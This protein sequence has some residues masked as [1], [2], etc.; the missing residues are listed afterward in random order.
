[1]ATPSLSSL[2]GLRPPPPVIAPSSVEKRLS[3]TEMRV[4]TAAFHRAR[5]Y[6]DG[7]DPPRFRDTVLQEAFPSMPLFVMQRVFSVW[8]YCENLSGGALTLKE[9]LIGVT[10]VWKGTPEEHLR[11]AFQLMDRHAEQE[12]NKRDALAF[13][14]AVARGD[15]IVAMD[16]TKNRQWNV[17]QFVE[18][19]FPTEKTLLSPTKF[20]KLVASHAFTWLVIID[21]IPKIADQF[22]REKEKRSAA[23][24]P[25]PAYVNHA[26]I[27]QSVKPLHVVDGYRAAASPRSRVSSPCNTSKTDATDEAPVMI[28]IERFGTDKFHAV[29][30]TLHK[31]IE[32]VLS[33]GES[34][35]EADVCERLKGL[36]SQP[37]LRATSTLVQCAGDFFLA[38]I[39][40]T[41]ECSR[42]RAASRAEGRARVLWW[43]LC[44]CCACS[45]SSAEVLRYLFVIL[46]DE[47]RGY[48][49]VEQLTTFILL[50]DSFNGDEVTA[51]EAVFLAQT[52]FDEVE[53]KRRSLLPES[54]G[55]HDAGLLDEA[56]MFRYRD[57]EKY[58]AQ[59]P[60]P[61]CSAAEIDVLFTLYH[62]Q[63]ARERGRKL[64][65]RNFLEALTAYCEEILR[66]D[67]A[68]YQ[69]D[70][71]L[72]SRSTWFRV[73]DILCDHDNES[74][75]PKCLKHQVGKLVT[76]AQTDEANPEPLMVIPMSLWLVLT[77][78]L[79]D[80]AGSNNEPSTQSWTELASRL[81]S[82]LSSIEITGAA[83]DKHIFHGYVVALD[84]TVVTRDQSEYRVSVSHAVV[85]SQLSLQSLVQAALQLRSTHNRSYRPQDSFFGEGD[86]SFIAQTSLADSR[87]V[88]LSQETLLISLQ[89]LDE[90]DDCFRAEVK[91]NVLLTDERSNSHTAMR[92]TQ[93]VSNP[94]ASS[95]ASSS[96]RTPKQSKRNVISGW[97]KVHGLANLGNTCFMNSALQCLAATPMLRDY[98]LKEEH[99]FDLST[100][101]IT[102]ST[103][104]RPRR[105]TA[106]PAEVALPKSS[107]I[108]VAFG[109]LLSE[110]NSFSS[111]G[112][113][114]GMAD[115]VS[116]K[117]MKGAVS[118]LFPHLSDGTQQDAQEFISSLLS[119]LSDELKRLP[120]VSSAPEPPPSVSSPSILARFAS[121]RSKTDSLTSLQASTAQ[122]DSSVPASQSILSELKF[123][124]NDS[125]GRA[126]DV[127]AKEW[128]ISHLISE[129][130]IVTA[131]FCGQFK[132]TL[133]CTHCGFTS[134][135]FEP[136]SS[137]QLPL[138][139]ET[140][141]L[142]PR[143]KHQHQ[144]IIVILHFLDSPSHRPSL[145]L[146][147]LAGLDWTI[148]QLLI[149][150]QQDH[151]TFSRS[152]TRRD[153]IAVSL[154][155]FTV[156]D[157]LDADA[158]VSSV[159]TPINVFEVDS[160]S[161]TTV[162]AS[163]PP[164]KPPIFESGALV[165]ARASHERWVKAR[166]EYFDASETMYHVLIEEANSGN[167]VVLNS[168]DV[169]P[170]DGG[171]D[172]QLFIRFVHRRPA[173]VPFYSTSPFRQVV[174]GFPFV[175]RVPASKLTGRGLYQLVRQKF[176]L[177][178]RQDSAARQPQFILKRVGNDGKSCELCHWSEQCDGC[179]IDRLDEELLDLTM[180]ETLAIEWLLDTHEPVDEWLSNGYCIA[181]H[182]SYVAYK[183]DNTFSLEKCLEMLCAEE[184][185]VARC[186][187]CKRLED[188]SPMVPH[189]KSLSLW[190]L[191]PILVIQL[192]RFELVA[193]R[194]YT[195]QRLNHNVNFQ[196][197]SFDVSRF[198]GASSEFTDTISTDRDEVTRAESF[199]VHE[200]QFPP[201]TASRSVCSY[202]LYG[203]VNHM[204]D[205][206]GGHYTAHIRHPDNA[207]WWLVDDASAAPANPQTLSPS[208]TAY[209]LFYVREDVDPTVDEE[210]VDF[211]VAVARPQALGDFFPR[212]ANTTRV[213]ESALR[214]LFK[215]QDFWHRSLSRMAEATEQKDDNC[216]VM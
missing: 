194:G 121:L 72:L 216:S 81:P 209:L 180:D 41:H 103:Q 38:Y 67:G 27:Q 115:V 35:K 23:T 130:S 119:S 144:Q 62:I 43:V 201:Q 133:R 197:D 172:R 182:T 11:F 141:M 71:C 203:V 13:C 24:Y 173:L 105:K 145:R 159:A 77:S 56:V 42:D 116:P 48:W 15:G 158:L 3:K 168:D 134:T 208:S 114:S 32:C 170:R 9:F 5:G 100:H 204:G 164:S 69:L 76:A 94:V 51:T 36:V 150:I 88:Q 214:A 80:R 192:K 104:Q 6:S 45:R 188:T 17:E 54:S 196:I 154:N 49:T 95:P 65:H 47:S 156:D 147:I 68:T 213:A 73:V 8:N 26:V 181:D 109:Q 85:E 118:T 122:Q 50:V 200:L 139:D 191:P 1:M 86:A 83:S 202:R 142:S 60:I 7:I 58:W 87:R 207:D 175:S 166:V 146:V 33:T 21:W 212:Q 205:L 25:K 34:V 215:Q 177:V 149:K 20:V 31:L 137:L 14:R 46:D 129:P 59:Y 63:L 98:F 12:L 186:S 16:E 183:L 57:F 169:R 193:S 29:K 75:L 53:S 125:D 70:F 102:G 179:I 152:G 184:Q 91:M 93:P 162:K 132:S 78:Y 4:A 18:L 99:L 44:I 22:E 84:L 55:D 112:T 185:L 174:C 176:C 126:D 151:P 165:Y 211:D 131:L 52:A 160:S 2:L 161:V 138:L 61:G 64:S 106:K 89:S 97:T 153:H 90:R 123:Q 190:S 157:Y 124:I 206:G 120:V 167:R 82:T 66:T 140:A 30:T 107:M 128:W 143:K 79:H 155:G 28:E 178:D 127:V 136:F 37:V 101:T 148:E 210:E 92:P 117:H 96:S 40:A 110:M 111:S 74:T 163:P 113:V 187:H 171:D 198:L 189:T 10:I 108:P 39:S 19:L 199:L 135:R 195:W